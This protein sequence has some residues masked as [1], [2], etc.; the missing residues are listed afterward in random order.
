MDSV[1]LSPDFQIVI[2]KAVREALRLR[3]GEKFRV[4]GYA[5]RVELVRVRPISKMR[6]VLR[7]MDTNLEREPDRL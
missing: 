2:P 4:F 3:I 7:G 1:T 5:N 6:G